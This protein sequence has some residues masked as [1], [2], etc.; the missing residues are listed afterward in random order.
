MKIS[1]MLYAMLLTLIDLFLVYTYEFYSPTLLLALVAVLSM[2]GMGLLFP[3][4][5]FLIKILVSGT[6]SAYCMYINAFSIYSIIIFSALIFH[7]S[8]L[9]FEAEKAGSVIR[10]SEHF[11][12]THRLR[13]QWFGS[14]GF[15]AGL[16]VCYLL[17]RDYYN[18]P[19]FYGFGLILAVGLLSL[20]YMEVNRTHNQSILWVDISGP[21]TKSVYYWRLVAFVA[22]VL[23]GVFWFSA[24]P[25]ADYLLE[26]RSNFDKDNN[27]A[28][29]DDDGSIIKPPGTRSGFNPGDVVLTPKVDLEL[30]D[31]P[32]FYVKLENKESRRLR[33]KPLY[34]SA[35]EL[36]YYA[37]N[38]WKPENVEVVWYKDEEDGKKD[39]KIDLGREHRYSI[40]HS[41]YLLRNGATS[42]FGLSGLHRI[43]LPEVFQSSMGV[44]GMRQGADDQRKKYTVHSNYYNF[45]FVRKGSLRVGTTDKKYTDLPDSEMMNRIKNLTAGLISPGDTDVEKIIKLKNYLARNCKYSLKVNNPTN[46]APLDNF[47]FHE[48]K[49]HCVLFASAYTLMLRSVGIPARMVNGFAGGDYDIKKGIYVMK[50]SNAH[51][52]TEVYCQNYGWIVCDATPEAFNAQAGTTSAENFDEANFEDVSQSEIATST[53]DA[54]SNSFFANKKNLMLALALLLAIISFGWQY[55]KKIPGITF[56]S[57]AQKKVTYSRPPYVQAFEDFCRTRGIQ[58]SKS[59]TIRELIAE[60]MQKGENDEEL[61][62]MAGYYYKVTFAGAQRDEAREKMWHGYISKKARQ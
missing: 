24:L 49:G 22:A 59:K 46:K 16:A 45:T 61:L 51:A 55:L 2:L 9:W 36:I 11:K 35:Q 41:I 28:K 62:N 13:H 7:S 27:T 3:I 38:I 12:V 54:N 40:R 4:N 5:S 34:I 60:L 8:S 47:I 14:L 23:F 18:F 17:V 6:F 31:K 20:I 10:W 39:G 33:N 43:D 56:M 32:E 30:S 1:S 25:V 53:A 44:M 26:V 37:G 57:G 48:R 21:L 42:V 52:W 19:E 29:D 15:F 50:S 58:V